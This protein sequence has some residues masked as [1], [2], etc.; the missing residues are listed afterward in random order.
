MMQDIVFRNNKFKGNHNGDLVVCAGS[1]LI[2]EG[3]E[4]EKSVI[5][6][7]RPHNYVFRNNHFNGGSVI[8]TTRTGVA[9]I[10]DNHYQSCKLSMVFDTKAIADGLVRPIG[11]TV[12]TL[13]L[14]LKNETL[15]NVTN[16]S[17]TYFHFTQCNIHSSRFVAG[18]E[19]QLV[20]FQ[21]CKITESSILYEAEGPPL[22]VK[23]EGAATKLAEEGLGLKRKRLVE[24]K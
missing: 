19:T 8:F 5:T 16:I 14:M 17:G 2:F 6:W 13:P 3:N 24:T 18:K 9:S 4:F 7:G 15:L 20:Q 10:H 21:D 12:I 11:Q 1:E 22:T 23:F